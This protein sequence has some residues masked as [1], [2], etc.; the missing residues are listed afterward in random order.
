MACLV[1]TSCHEKPVN[2]NAS[3][4]LDDFSCLVSP[5]M[6][7]SSKEIRREIGRLVAADN[8]STLSDFY[9]R[10]YYDSRSPYVWID[11]KGIDSR[12]DT[13]LVRLQ[14]LG[15]LGLNP[16]KFR[17]SEIEHDLKTARSLSL[18]DG[19][20]HGDNINKVY[21]RLEYNLTKALYRYAAGQRFGY[22]NPYKLL[23]RLDKVDEESSAYRRL[24]DLGSPT[25][26][27]SFYRLALHKVSVDSLAS[28]LNEGEPQN[29]Y[30][31]RL[32]T[33]L[34]SDEAS[35]YDRL[36]LLVNLE[37]S[38]WRVTDTPHDHDK[39]VMVNLPSLHLMAV[40][41]DSAITMR[42]GFGSQKTKTPLLSSNIKRM[43][44]NPQWIIPRS[45]VKTSIVPRLGNEWYFRSHHYFIRDRATGKN[46]DLSQASREALLN[47]SQ[48][49]IQE[50][51]EGNALGRIIFRFDNNFSIYLHDTSSRDVFDRE[52]RDVSH[53][54][55]RVQKPYEL[56]MFLL[57]DKDSTL[58]R[59]IV[60][61]MNADVSPV[62]KKK[63]FLTEEQ[64]AVADT[65]RRDMLIGN[66]KV[67][68]TVPVFIYYYTLYPDATGTLRI[69]A[70]VYGYDALIYNS[71]RN[72]I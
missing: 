45:I 64:Q 11:R 22:T 31:K 68:P 20:S 67:K 42:I 57:E 54:C 43:D 17:V 40:D 18:A 51:G 33:I 34:N 29:P 3:M 2:P 70:D 52:S 38:R 55:I 62:G 8:D 65:L 61:S 6:S 37:R 56:A 58:E 49:A 24:Y 19:S 9:A 48:L 16:A 69:Y 26:G 21:A 14:T 63:G 1:V 50:G 66:V 39:Y 59:R 4:T 7:V 23:N 5:E 36:L 30:Y 10:K 72:Y 46:L 12:A 13:L 44:V 35:R 15:C 25:A 32:L 41:G 27:A 60:Y 53:G 71:L 47:G 28:F